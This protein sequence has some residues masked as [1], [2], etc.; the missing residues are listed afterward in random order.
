MHG[1]GERYRPEHYRLIRHRRDGTASSP[2]PD[3]LTEVVRCPPL[4]GAVRASALQH[5]S[6]AQVLLA[7]MVLAA[8]AVRLWWSATRGQPSTD[9]SLGRSRGW[10]SVRARFPGRD[11]EVF[12]FRHGQFRSRRTAQ[13]CQPEHDKHSLLGQRAPRPAG[14]S[15]SV[16]ARLLL[17]WDG[18]QH[19]DQRFVELSERLREHAI[20]PGSRPDS[21][22]FEVGHTDC[23]ERELR[24]AGAQ[25]GTA[26]CRHRRVVPINDFNPTA[27]EVVVGR[28]GPF[29]PF[30]G[31][32]MSDDDPE[33][34]TSS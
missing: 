26:P 16:W 21:N 14:S 32:P 27:P 24:P 8:G 12:E 22:M 5:C 28:T 6:S 34:S 15:V 30:S 1:C 3:Q 13:I 29:G 19:F 18:A 23:I 20:Q 2:T 4:A 31:G 33:F 25:H 9:T 17:L 11:H 10:L 7:T